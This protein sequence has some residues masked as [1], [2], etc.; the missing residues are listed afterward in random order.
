MNKIKLVSSVDSRAVDETVVQKLILNGVDAIKINMNEVSKEDARNIIGITRILNRKLDTGVGI[1]LEIGSPLIHIGRIQDGE[2]VFKTDDKI[3]LYVTDVLGDE[4]KVSVNYPEII[5]EVSKNNIITIG[6]VK[7][8]VT[9]KGYDYIICEVIDGGIVKEYEKLQIDS[10]THTAFLRV[11]DVKDIE[12]A[13]EMKVDYLILP[14]VSN[15]EDVMQVTDMLIG[16]R[17][18]HTNVITRVDSKDVIDDIDDIIKTSD[19]ILIDRNNL[20]MEIPLERIPG[21]QKNIVNKCLTNGKI[22][23]ASIDIPLNSKKDPNRVEVQDIANASLDGVDALLINE[24]VEPDGDYVSSIKKLESILGEIETSIDYDA[25]YEN[26][27]REENT[28]VTGTIATNVAS[29]ANRLKCKAIITPTITGYTARKISRFRPVCPI[30]AVSP[31][32]DTVTSLSLYF[33]VNPVLIDDLDSLDRIIK[34]SESITKGLISV[35]KGDKIIIT[36]GYPFKESKST[37]FMKIEEM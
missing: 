12:F 3:R 27:S 34:I 7:L 2:T 11:K 26:A 15:N 37:N 14:R 22:S 24:V 17:N 8:K 19:G 16:L 25:M 35:K 30:I 33:G 28:D 18:D 36:G 21:L 23:L 29:T 20:S 4:T 32:S 10:G 31:N 5:E 13:S 6:N 9:D 1:V